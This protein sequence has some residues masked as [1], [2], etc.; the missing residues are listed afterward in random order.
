MVSEFHPVCFCAIYW[1][2]RFRELLLIGP[3]SLIAKP[4]K[5]SP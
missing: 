5:A 2:S 1:I 4:R 3:V